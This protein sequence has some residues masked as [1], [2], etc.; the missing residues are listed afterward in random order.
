MFL[1]TTSGARATTWRVIGALMAMAM[2]SWSIC[3][4]YQATAGP[5]RHRLGPWISWVGVLIMISGF[6][7]LALGLPIIVDL[8]LR[9]LEE[10]QY[11][12]ET[13]IHH[14]GKLSKS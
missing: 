7:L 9:L 1:N 5:Q 8:F 13:D 14:R 6:L 12:E 2:L 11:P 3:Y 4:G 10:L